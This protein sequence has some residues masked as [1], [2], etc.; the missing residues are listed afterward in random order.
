MSITPQYKKE[1]N[2]GEALLL[3]LFVTK[4]CPAFFETPWT[5]ACQAPLSTEEIS[6]ARIL[7]WV[8]ISFSRASFLPGE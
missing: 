3:S 7:E 6:Q 8:G 5:I 4:S 2:V 1:K